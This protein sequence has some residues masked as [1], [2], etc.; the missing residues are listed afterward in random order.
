LEE[1]D[2]FKL[3]FEDYEYLDKHLSDK[4][5][6]KNIG[7]YNPEMNVMYEI[8]YINQESLKISCGI[9]TTINTIVKCKCK[10]DRKE[11][12]FHLKQD[13]CDFNRDNILPKFEKNKK[14]IY[15]DNNYY[16]RR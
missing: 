15:Y 4:F 10:F 7:F 14:I 13:E 8:Y 1:I 3:H 9:Y 11:S 2:I 5:K 12:Q 6:E 16:F